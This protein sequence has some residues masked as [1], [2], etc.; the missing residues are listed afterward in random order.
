M[1]KD[2][3]EVLENTGLTVFIVGLIFLMINQSEI[4][5]N[6]GTIMVVLG[7]IVSCASNK[8][9]LDEIDKEKE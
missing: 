5:S 9:L 6:V 7:T 1:K 4:V 3:L 8:I 2:D